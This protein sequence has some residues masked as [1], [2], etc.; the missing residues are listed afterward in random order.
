M[1]ALDTNA[2]IAWQKQH[3]VFMGHYDTATRQGEDIAVPAIVRYEARRELVNPL[4]QRRLAR[5]DSLLI[6]H[7]TLDLDAQTVDVA[8]QIYDLLRSD[9]NLIDDA[10][11]LIA[12][13]VLRHDAVLVT[14][15]TSH[16]E[17]VPNLKKV[18]WQKE[19]P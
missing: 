12:A 18:D 3:K 16:F 4:Y 19:N 14:N 17:R 11:L 6:L 13:T 7:P 5:L 15:N 8:I 1:F 2:L 9:G 10:D